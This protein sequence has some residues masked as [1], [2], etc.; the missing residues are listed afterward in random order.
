[1]DIKSD[2]ISVEDE[3]LIGWSDGACIGN[4]GPMG[5]GGILK[6][7]SG[8]EIAQFSWPLGHGTNNEAEYLGL[9]HLLS[10]A[11]S[12]GARGLHAYTD[13]ELVA[14][15]Y[16]GEY[17][18]KQ[19]H[20]RELLSELRWV[21]GLLPD[22]FRLEWIPRSKNSLADALAGRAARISRKRNP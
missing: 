6:N 5:A 2:V 12:C 9:H 1:M 13:S 11:I 21:S 19:D 17:K 14:K 10:L 16:S 18:A 8:I 20:I 3:I 22:G 4:P 7:Q 15:Q